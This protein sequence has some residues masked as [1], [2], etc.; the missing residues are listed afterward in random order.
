MLEQLS[1]YYGQPVKPVGDFCATIRKFVNTVI[2]ASDHP[3]ACKY[4][5]KADRL[6]SAILDVEKSNLLYR[7]LYLGEEPRTKRC[8]VHKGRW[9]GCVF[10]D[11]HCE[12]QHGA[13]VTGWLP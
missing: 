1:A 9:S 8:P 12:C 13:N 7:M 2:E 6:A 10:E 11:G 5:N 4:D 3:D